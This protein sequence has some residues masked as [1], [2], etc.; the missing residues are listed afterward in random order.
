MLKHMMSKLRY[1]RW[2]SLRYTGFGRAVCTAAVVLA[3]MAVVGIASPC[4]AFA[5]S[6]SRG[7]LQWDKPVSYKPPVSMSKTDTVKMK[8]QQHERNLFQLGLDYF[9]G[10]DVPKDVA[11]AVALWRKAAGQGDV[12]AQSSLGYVYYSGLGVAQSYEEAA[13]WYREAAEAGA[14]DAQHNLGVMYFYGQG[15]EKDNALAMAWCMVANANGYKRAMKELRYI[16]GG[17]TP[18]QISQAQ[19]IA[20]EKLH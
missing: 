20:M 7:D 3:V 19:S 17:A 9:K 1:P 16:A 12:D 11:R 2:E 5:D 10:H 14:A 15:V 18:G 8:V 13:K 6:G 4:T